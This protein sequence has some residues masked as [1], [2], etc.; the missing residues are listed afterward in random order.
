MVGVVEVGGWEG[1]KLGWVGEGCSLGGW[2]KV[3]VRVGEWE[4][5]VVGVGGK[6]LKWMGERRL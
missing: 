2:E 1:L 6:W 3:V 5:V 4:G